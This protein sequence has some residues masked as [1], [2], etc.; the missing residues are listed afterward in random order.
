M[1]VEQ[2]IF[3]MKSNYDE[4]LRASQ[5][6]WN[7]GHDPWPWLGYFARTLEAGYD[8]FEGRVAEA[9]S[10]AGGTKQARIRDHVLNH[11][12]RDFRIRELRSALPGASPAT[13]LLVLAQMR[14]KG[15]IIV[16]GTDPAARCRRTADSPPVPPD[17][18]ADLD[19]HDGR[20]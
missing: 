20:R 16:D 11:A 18:D 15:H 19:R 9:R 10:A 14:K 7:E 13:T 2:R 6:A 8:R 17:A 1:S 3:E 12:P 5:V 4:A